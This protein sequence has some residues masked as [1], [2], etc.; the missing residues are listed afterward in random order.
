MNRRNLF[1]TRRQLFLKK[2]GFV[3]KSCFPYINLE[4]QTPYC[5]MEF[6]LPVMI[7]K[8]EQLIS[9]KKVTFTASQ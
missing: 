6:N 4:S 3:V 9:W 7:V 8:Y 1:E 2:I 5:N